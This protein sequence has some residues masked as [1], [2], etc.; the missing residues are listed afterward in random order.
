M[1]GP[2]APASLRF[3]TPSPLDRNLTKAS[4]PRRGGR[5]GGRRLCSVTLFVEQVSRLGVVPHLAL[6]DPFVDPAGQ[7]LLLRLSAFLES[8]G[9]QRIIDAQGPGRNDEARQSRRQQ[10][11]FG[12]GIDDIL[13][14]EARKTTRPAAA[15][16]ARSPSA[17]VAALVRSMWPRDW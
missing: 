14:R 13:H 2:S 8:E 10:Q 4:W 16:K 1:R 12:D 7:R 5:G 3:S 9:L 17:T 15:G 11:A 6:D